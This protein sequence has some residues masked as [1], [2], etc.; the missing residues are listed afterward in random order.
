MNFAK[1]ICNLCN[2]QGGY[3]MKTGCC[4]NMIHLNCVFDL[5]KCPYCNASATNVMKMKLDYVQ[6]NRIE[7]IKQIL[8]NEL[9]QRTR[10]EKARLDSQFKID[11]IIT[12]TALKD[13]W[14]STPSKKYNQIIKKQRENVKASRKARKI[15]KN[16]EF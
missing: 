16:V 2:Q 10:I 5:K 15:L 9:I 3:L 13:A 8:I 4:T 11:S 6:R 14:N 12:I 1:D 7:I